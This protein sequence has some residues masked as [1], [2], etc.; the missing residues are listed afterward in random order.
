MIFPYNIFA[1]LVTHLIAWDKNEKIRIKQ[2]NKLFYNM[3]NDRNLKNL[4]VNKIIICGDLNTNPDSECVKNILDNKFLSVF[5]ISKDSENDGNYTMVIDTV[6]ERLK[7]L[8]YDYIF[9]NNNIEIINKVLPVNYLDFEKGL[10]NENFPS[11]HL[12]LFTEFKFCDKNKE[13]LYDYNQIIYDH[14]LNYNDKSKSNDNN[15][16]KNSN[17]DDKTFIKEEKISHS[18]DN[19]YNNENNNKEDIK[20]NEI[21]EINIKDKEIIN[22][23]E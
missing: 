10:P 1:I 12:Y 18:N 6:D 2:I 14:N 5:D 15:D 17:K 23:K 16:G 7:K 19:N 4:K 9:V 13:N 20:E 3:A 8:K 21:K 22:N 11:D